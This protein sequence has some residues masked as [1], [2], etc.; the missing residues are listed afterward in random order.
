MVNN[1]TMELLKE[2]DR[3]VKMGIEAIDEVIPRVDDKGLKEVLTDYN[4][5]HE[6][7]KDELEMLLRSVGCEGAE[8]NIMA[9]GM[10]AVKTNF[11]MM[12][13]DSDRT[14]ADL[15]TDGCDM[16]IK[17]LNKYL[18]EYAAA[19]ETVKDVTRRIIKVEEDFEEDL[20]KYL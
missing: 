18:N 14:V 17:S 8:P 9:K 4:I 7:L 16:G 12:L 1:D 10:S 6:K 5:R 3:G 13:E 15:M 2:C 19:E 20:K 11:K